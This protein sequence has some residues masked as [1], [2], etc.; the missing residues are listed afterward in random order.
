MQSRG[1]FIYA[2]ATPSMP[3]IVK[4]GATDRDPIHR[5][6]EANAPN[7]WG[8]PE[9]YVATCTA[10]VADAFATERA[11]HA[12]VAARRVSPRREFF[13]MTD[14]EVRALFA[15]VAPLAQ[16]REAREAPA[17]VAPEAALVPVAPEAAAS[18]ARGEGSLLHRAKLRAWVEARY[19]HVPLRDKDAGTRLAVLYAAYAACVPPVHA[20]PL[21]RSAF[22]RALNALFPDVGP[23]TNTANT[24]GGL[25]LLR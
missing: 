21:G 13:R 14:D 8:P 7:T 15:A 25:Y 6:S 22:A 9:P 18:T 1:G 3:G 4:I 19:A 16:A 17:P 24:V 2:F 10:A 20:K 11:V 12:L 5:L 23:H